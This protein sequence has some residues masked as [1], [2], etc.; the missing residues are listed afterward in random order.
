M[1]TGKGKGLIFG[2]SGGC[3]D[4]G[5]WCPLAGNAA[6]GGIS[7]GMGAPNGGGNRRT[8]SLKVE[9][10]RNGRA[11][12]DWG[13][14]R[15]WPTKGDS[16]IAKKFTDYTGLSYYRS[17]VTK[18]TWKT[19]KSATPRKG[20][21]K[22]RDSGLEHLRKEIAAFRDARDWLQFHNPKDMAI[23]ISV[24]ASEL[25]E[26]FLWK[27]KVEVDTCVRDK[28]EE[29]QDEIAD[30]GIYLIELADVLKID[31]IAAM[32]SKLAKNGA[33]YPVAKAKGS[34]KKYTELA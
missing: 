33:K 16:G 12:P 15:S 8:N 27:G 31:I 19:G 14:K 30:I 10:G 17:G 3:G 18:K 26:H 2:A 29:I 20:A 28:K 23:A 7:V 13:Q 34:N 6:L 5:A 4:L 21:L 25:L 1:G 22:V 11:N 24:E 9:S 32:E